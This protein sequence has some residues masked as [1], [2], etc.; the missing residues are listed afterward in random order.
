MKTDYLQ[1]KQNL[2]NT[3]KTYF[4]FSDLEKFYSHHSGSLKTLLSRWAKRGAIYGLKRGFYAFDIIRVDY[5]HLANNIYGDSYISF[6]YALYFHNLINQ[7]PSTVTLVTQKRS[8]TITVSNWTFEYTHLKNEL[9]FGCELKDKIYIATPEKALADLFYL[10]ARGKR[11]FETDSLE[12]G[13]I[14]FK[15]LTAILKRFPLYVTKRA[16]EVLK[17][18]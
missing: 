6:E 11:L 7:V 15:N 3:G 17:L 10:M 5:L 16:N 4:Q 12:K 13:K 1:F 9:M 14:N 8:R 2:E 18:N